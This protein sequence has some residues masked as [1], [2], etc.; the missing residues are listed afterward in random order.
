MRKTRR[1]KTDAFDV[2][3]QF[4]GRRRMEGQGRKGEQIFFHQA[5]WYF[6]D[7]P[8]WLVNFSRLKVKRVKQQVILI[9]NEL[10][11]GKVIYDGVRV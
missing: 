10:K 3:R 9:N 7:A 11:E 4:K 6:G 8:S 1:E 2:K 5:E